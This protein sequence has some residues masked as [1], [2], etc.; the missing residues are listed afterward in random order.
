MVYS[1]LSDSG[2]MTVL[3]SKFDREAESVFRIDDATGTGESELVGVCAAIPDPVLVVCRDEIVHANAECCRLLAAADR[4]ALIGM[5]VE[6]ILIGRLPDVEYGGASRPVQTTAMSLD[7][8][9]I[10]TE[11]RSARTCWKGVKATLL[12]LREQADSRAALRHL[13]GQVQ[14]LGETLESSTTRHLEITRQ[15]YKAKEAADL[16]NRTK[17]E[18]L[19]NMSHE[20]RTP[21]NA[22]L[23]F[24]EIIK[25]EM[26]GG[27]A[28][29]QYVEY[30]RDI[31][32]CGA[33]LLDIIND[34]L[35]LSKI[36]AGRF[37]LHEE[38]ICLGDIFGPV[39]Q[40]IK[41]RAEEK[42]HEVSIQISD[43]FPRIVGDKRALK[44]VFL[45][46][47][48]NAVKFMAEPGKI[49]VTARLAEDGVE[50][51]VA[52][53]GIGIAP[54]DMEKVLLPF[55]QVDSPLA[56]DH[57]GT[58]LGLP[59]VQAMVQLH[60]GRLVID[61]TIGEGTTVTIVL[62]KKRLLFPRSV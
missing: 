43:D 16:A 38:E 35:D 3:N 40:L 46:L 51:S 4:S 41:G 53:K 55:G 27:I 22:I 49:V 17:S 47:L 14:L 42:G 24:S 15:L 45:N 29:P 11:F 10:E 48:S 18:F 21:L 26:F 6:E 36:E 19:A 31:H 50:I 56:R 61:S 57:Q 60:G 62:P 28:V 52:D 54:E 39:Y 44:Q 12:I 13:R 7:G 9:M 1:Y 25:D 59:L 32:L 58:G 33:H 30:A 8:V 5:R 37:E 23:G 34:I 20:L 2:V